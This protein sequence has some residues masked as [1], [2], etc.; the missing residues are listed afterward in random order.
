MKYVCENVFAY[1]ACAS[2][3]PQSNMYKQNQ[4]TKEIHTYRSAGKTR[5]LHQDL[6]FS[7]VFAD[8]ID[9]VMFMLMYV[10][11]KRSPCL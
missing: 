1:L 11:V 5:S 4:Y 3:V 7:L 8:P 9:L 2:Q 10:A 6:K